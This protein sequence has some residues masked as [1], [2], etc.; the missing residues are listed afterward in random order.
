MPASYHDIAGRLR[1]IPPGSLLPANAQER[2]RRMICP[3]PDT[4][5]QGRFPQPAP[6][7]LNGTVSRD[8]HAVAVFPGREQSERT[9]N[10]EIPGSVLR[11]APE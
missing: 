11:T 2:A 6:E 10:L 4:M 7:R 9:R 5:E 1:A 3:K 8:L